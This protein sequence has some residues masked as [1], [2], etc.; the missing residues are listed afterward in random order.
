MILKES[1]AYPCE[2]FFWI[3]NNE[4]VGI[5]SE[6]PHYNY[7]YALNGKTHQNTWN[8]FK[9]DYLADGKVVEFDYYPR[10]RIMIDPEYDLTT[11]EFTEYSCLVFLDNCINNPECKQMIVDYYNL[12]IPAIKHIHWMMLGERAGI[13]HYQCH[14]C[15]K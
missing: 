12:D 8:S 14:W 15:K 9:S 1:Q 4:V 7:E 10:G 6:V 2:G 13:D 5:L 11:K 3:I